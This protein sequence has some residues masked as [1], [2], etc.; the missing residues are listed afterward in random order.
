MVRRASERDIPAHAT[1]EEVNRMGHVMRM[2]P[3]TKPDRLIR[4]NRHV[5]KYLCSHPGC[6]A[7]FS[8]HGV[9]LQ[10]HDSR[11]M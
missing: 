9:S 2:N 7:V 6:G 8:N 4:E 1:Q 11:F 10:S 5:K 3:R